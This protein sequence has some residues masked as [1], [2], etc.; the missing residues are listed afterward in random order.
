MLVSIS[1]LLLIAVGGIAGAAAKADSWARDNRET[2]ICQI[3]IRVADGARS[4]SWYQKMFSLEPI[5]AESPR[6]T[7]PVSVPQGAKM[8]GIPE[9]EIAGASWVAG[10]DSMSQLELFQISRPPPVALPADFGPRY[11]G[12]GVVGL[13]VADFEAMRDRTR[14]AG[15][16][17]AI[18]GTRPKRSMWMKDPDGVPLEIMERDPLGLHGA[19]QAS[20]SIR[21]VTL[22]VSDLQKAKRFWTSAVGLS[23]E[24][25]GAYIFNAF[26]KALGAGE[27][28]QEVV[29][30]GTV[31]IRLLR[32]RGSAVVPRS[33]DQKLSGVY[34]IAATLDD[35][36]SWEALIQRVR[37]LG[38]PLLSIESALLM[39]NDAGAIYGHDD[40]ENI[41]EFGFV[42]P[43][44]EGKYGWRR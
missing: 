16:Q 37:A 15:T 34:H 26:P 1:T 42:L 40:Q 2:P 29:K 10:A 11:A 30:G 3:A 27:W 4:R 6:W 24:S 41:V 9:F 18:T 43:G 8:L 13:V 35:R 14:A 44:H 19:H 28:D 21:S 20:A 36:T 32:P 7:A 23:G 5:P 39:G 25:P 38:Y 12:Y 31:L 22:T 17:Y 33:P